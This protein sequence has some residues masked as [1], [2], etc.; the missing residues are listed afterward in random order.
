[1]EGRFQMLENYLMIRMP[2]EID[3]HQA[4][5]LSKDADR[6]ILGEQV[7]HIVFDF[8][9]TRFMDSSGVGVVVGRYK[10]IACFGG[11]VYAVHANRQIMRIIQV[12]GLKKIL[13]IIDEEAEDE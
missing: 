6:Y 1:M 13:H 5:S 11:R 3:H 10:K 7:K 2:E 12:S 8:E 4:A 9:D